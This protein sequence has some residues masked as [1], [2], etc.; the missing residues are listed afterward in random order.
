MTYN[1][2]ATQNNG[3]IVSS[4][5]GVTGENVSYT[6][7]SLKRLIAAS[8][9]GTGGVQWGYTHSYDGFGNLTSKLATSGTAPSMYTGVNSATNQVGT[10]DANGNWLG[11]SGP[12]YTWNV[13][14]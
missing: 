4:V 8:T 3:Q 7:D 12:R 10:S 6:Y 11:A 14:N 13:E 5:D 1:D 9:S 2:S